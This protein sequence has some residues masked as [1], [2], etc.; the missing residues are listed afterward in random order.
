MCAGV[1]IHQGRTGFNANQNLRITGGTISLILT[2]IGLILASLAL[3]ASP[4]FS[5][6]FS[7]DA[8]LNLQQD[9]IQN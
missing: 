3:L 4:F 6:F 1:L 5:G 7:K 2:Y 9:M 8:I